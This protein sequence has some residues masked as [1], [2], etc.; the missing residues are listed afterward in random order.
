[1][2]QASTVSLGFVP[3]RRAIPMHESGREDAH[4]GREDSG[5]GMSRLFCRYRTLPTFQE[6]FYLPPTVTDKEAKV[7]GLKQSILSKKDPL[8]QPDCHRDQNA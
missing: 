2:Q 7:T 8:P 4:R 3:D 6:L 1:M 5:R